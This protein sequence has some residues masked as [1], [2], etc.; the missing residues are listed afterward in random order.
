MVESIYR[1]LLDHIIISP[2]MIYISI[3]K[4]VYILALEMKLPKKTF[5]PIGLGLQ[6]KLNEI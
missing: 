4:I 6:N 5:P 1:L 3:N 2:E